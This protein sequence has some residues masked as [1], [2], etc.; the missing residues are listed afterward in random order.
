MRL[1]RTTD[2]SD[3]S[4]HLL[5]IIYQQ[6]YVSH[7]YPQHCYKFPPQAILGPEYILFG[8]DK[9]LFFLPAAGSF[10]DSFAVFLLRV[11]SLLDDAIF[12]NYRYLFRR[13]GHLRD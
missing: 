1:T 5:Q 12:I 6:M 7:L 8:L 9:W 2:I 3:I 4:F 11:V 13:A 10:S